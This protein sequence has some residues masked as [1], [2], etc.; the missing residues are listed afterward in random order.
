MTLAAD[1]LRERVR[2]RLEEQR[3][4]VRDLLR[5]RDQLQGSL[6]ARY[7]RCGKEGCACREGR[8]HGPYYV[9]STRSAGKGGFVYLDDGQAQRARELVRR[10]R[11]FRAGLRRLRA[12]NLELV[13][14]LRRYQQALLR[15]G[16]KRLAAPAP[17]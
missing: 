12:L 3:V 9:L 11:E 2:T 15:K 10:Q 1:Q 14:L 5:R 7:G 17:M 6:F 4:L 8:G 16:Q 13:A